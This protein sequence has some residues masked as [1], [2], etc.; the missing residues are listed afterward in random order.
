MTE[1]TMEMTAQVHCAADGGEGHCNY[2]RCACWEMVAECGREG[3]TCGDKYCE[4]CGFAHAVEEE[5]PPTYISTRLPFEDVQRVEA[6]A[7]YARQTVADFVR[8]AVLRATATHLELETVANR[9]GKGGRPRQRLSAPGV[10]TR[11]AV[12]RRLGLS[13]LRAGL[14]CGGVRRPAGRPPLLGAK[15]CAPLSS[16]A[17]ALTADRRR[18]RARTAPRLRPRTAPTS[19]AT[20]TAAPAATSGASWTS[21]RAARLSG[22]AVRTHARAAGPQWPKATRRTCSAVRVGGGCSSASA[23]V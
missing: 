19:R 9:V 3:C 2:A 4:R 13:A 20:S 23:S 15:R 6:A 21:T 14:P 16:S 5:C 11:P 10:G 12:A 1:Q 7:T 8:E 18:G 17:S 22:Y